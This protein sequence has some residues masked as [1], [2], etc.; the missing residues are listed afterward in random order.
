MG[1]IVL[2]SSDRVSLPALKSAVDN[3]LATRPITEPRTNEVDEPRRESGSN[4]SLQSDLD[5]TSGEVFQ[6]STNEGT[7]QALIEA[8]LGADVDSATLQELLS[9]EMLLSD[10]ASS[11]KK[12]HIKAVPLVSAKAQNSETSLPPG[13]DAAYIPEKKTILVRSDLSPVE[14][15]RA[16][17]EEYGEFLADEAKQAG[18]DVGPGD[19]GARVA[20]ILNGQLPDPEDRVAS[21]DDSVTV[22][23]EGATFD[24][25]A[26]KTVSVKEGVATVLD[27]PVQKPQKN[28]R[29]DP[30]YISDSDFKEKRASLLEEMGSSFLGESRNPGFVAKDLKTLSA[31]RD[32]SEKQEKLEKKA[33]E[34]E[35]VNAPPFDA[36]AIVPE[37]GAKADKTVV[38]GADIR[39]EGPD[40]QVIEAWDATKGNWV[41][42]GRSDGKKREI[43][44]VQMNQKGGRA[45]NIRIRNLTQGDVIIDANSPSQAKASRNGSGAATI[46]FNTNGKGGLNPKN[47]DA[48]ITFTGEVPPTVANKVTAASGGKA[49]VN[50]DGTGL[51]TSDRIEVKKDGK[52]VTAAEVA[53]VGGGGLF[54]DGSN[55][56]YRWVPP[57]WDESG[58]VPEDVKIDFEYDGKAPEVRFVNIDDKGET[59]YEKI[60]LD[61]E[62]IENNGGR[63]YFNYAT[64]SW[65]AKEFGNPSD[66]SGTTT[67]EI[68]LKPNKGDTTTITTPPDPAS[69]PESDFGGANQQHFILTALAGGEDYNAPD[70]MDE[71]EDRGVIR[72]GA[73]GEITINPAKFTSTD[74]FNIFKIAVANDPG[75]K[76][77][78]SQ[79]LVDIGIS[80]IDQENIDKI[81]G[82]GDGVLDARD[83]PL[84]SYRR[85]RA[86]SLNS[87]DFFL[88]P[89]VGSDVMA[90]SVTRPRSTLLRFDLSSLTNTL[91]SG[92]PAPP[93]V[94]SDR[95]VIQGRSYVDTN[96]NDKFDAGDTPLPGMRVFIDEDAD[97]I[98]DQSELSQLT[99][100]DGTYQFDRKSVGNRIIAIEDPAFQ[101]IDKTHDRTGS[102]GEPHA[103]ILDLDGEIAD[104]PADR[105]EIFGLD[106]SKMSIND[107]ALEGI[108]TNIIIVDS[109]VQRDHIALDGVSIIGATATAEK[110]SARINDNPASIGL[111]IHGT[112]VTAAAAKVA[113]KADYIVMDS[114]RVSPEGHLD[115]P[116]LLDDIIEFAKQKP[117]EPI[118]VNISEIWDLS[119]HHEISPE[120]IE[121]LNLPNLTIVTSA[122]NN[123]E[124]EEPDLWNNSL[125]RLPNV[126][127]VSNAPSLTETNGS[128][129]PTFVTTLDD[130]WTKMLPDP[131]TN[132]STEEDEGTSFS[133]P[134]VTGTI[135][136]MQ[137]YSMRR[138]GRMLRPDE[139]QTLLNKSGDWGNNQTPSR[140]DNKS[141]P[142]RKL[143]PA[144]LPRAID[145]LM[146]GRNIIVSENLKNEGLVVDFTLEPKDKEPK[147]PALPTA[148]STVDLSS[149]ALDFFAD[150]ALLPSPNREATVTLGLSNMGMVYMNPGPARS[151]DASFAIVG[152]MARSI[153]PSGISV[154]SNTGNNSVEDLIDR[155]VID[156]DY[157]NGTYR[158]D[159]DKM[160][161]KEKSQVRAH[162]LRSKSLSSVEKSN[163][164]KRLGV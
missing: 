31:D 62:Q 108:G 123:D 30:R 65:V 110:I 89:P 161:E 113:P 162:I 28:F 1:N 37:T 103:E 88:K 33:R 3:I 143:N 142:F 32:W 12:P 38:I 127:V 24:A 66:I 119:S 83:I 116:G 95:S 20:N 15:K 151:K 155:G 124:D 105:S 87:A 63:K 85:D 67:I 137:E 97:G 54:N 122:G 68:D 57:N 100:N 158:V 78:P 29:K 146:G 133:A 16:V 77:Q 145:A 132:F 53:D 163:M 70:V 72:P 25:K 102:S 120:T 14:Q 7:N 144:N 71:L 2:R 11:K 43:F 9:I 79:F 96:G 42:L 92:S 139:I 154:R 153:V 129:G 134:V 112:Q 128:F 23:Y 6:L 99:D 80:A 47:A 48:V 19:A 34:P 73:E 147:A 76:S 21:V 18:A 64:E 60:E 50:I 131:T 94:P 74:R 56:V 8:I 148:E 98:F 86:M 140:P 61:D 58:K 141:G 55:P 118:V 41:E 5:E 91:E 26:K 114:F 49:S 82:N 157:E 27:V 152:L 4:K 51:I 10:A 40:A 135:A 69:N 13:V 130:E 115:Q 117:D 159:S 149:N 109:P 107:V 125:A 93:F 136:L 44:S 17:Q 52:W 45:P 39:L 59:S 164:I 106:F 75:I 160:S 101:A 138:H 126:V 150:V 84:I 111:H 22:T 104:S 35:F 81:L 121:A 90:R 36:K 156:M 46:A